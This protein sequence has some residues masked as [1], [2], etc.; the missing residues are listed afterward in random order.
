MEKINLTINELK[1]MIN[2]DTEKDYVEFTS[3]MLYHPKLKSVELSKFPFICGDL[4]YPKIAMFF[5][6]QKGYTEIVS[7]FFNKAK[8][9]EK[10]QEFMKFEKRRSFA[11]PQDSDST[12]E[13]LELKIQNIKTRLSDSQLSKTT[14]DGLN[15]EIEKI[16]R[17][18]Y[19]NKNKF[20]MKKSMKDDKIL[21]NNIMLMLKLL[22]ATSYPAKFNISSSFNEYILQKSPSMFEPEIDHNLEK[23]SYLKIDNKTLTITKITWLNDIMNHPLYR[24][25]MELLVDYKK[26][27]SKEVKR[28]DEELEE[29]WNFLKQKFL[30]GRY[31]ITYAQKSFEDYLEKLK[32]EGEI[33]NSNL[34]ELNY[35]KKEFKENIIQLIEQLSKFETL[36]KR[37]FFS[38]SNTFY[39]VIL[40]IKTLFDALRDSKTIITNIPV[41]FSSN[42]NR[43]IVDFKKIYIWSRIKTEYIKTGNIN[44]NLEGEDKDI[45]DEIMNK[46]KSLDKFLF[47]ST[48]IKDFITPERVC[49]NFNLQRMIMEYS[50]NKKPDEVNSDISTNREKINNIKNE[51]EKFKTSQEKTKEGNTNNIENINKL[52]IL[53]MNAKELILTKNK[54]TQTEKRDFSRLMQAIYNELI[55]MQ[56]MEYFKNK[57]N[58]NN[59]YIGACNINIYKVDVPKYEIYLAIDSIEGEYDEKTIKNVR[60]VR[61]SLYLG[62]EISDFFSG[63]SPYDI[64]NHRNIVS[65]RDLQTSNSSTQN[66]S[67]ELLKK[68]KGGKKNKTVRFSNRLFKNHRGGSSRKKNKKI[69]IS[70]RTY[71]NIHFLRNRNY[72][73]EL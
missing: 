6:A 29:E 31:K 30:D 45:A 70:T 47:F 35:N 40:N 3:S 26:Q 15:N 46:N 53:E 13:R 52:K 32:N 66:N 65:E 11:S 58:F 43:A 23:I 21:S 34:I 20:Y 12:K 4:E 54:T 5:I 64:I 28:I 51:I 39:M 27:M 42:L 37:F 56:K 25:L 14:S 22:F 61:D 7:L 24:K 18:L 67:L 9:R 19:D 49:S 72:T 41:D 38:D 2:T 16:Q 68:K 73:S 8:F 71:N 17:E 33:N 60:C 50:E 62:N 57:E 69:G 10:M 1:I 36:Q 44:I 55:Y 59:M 63:K 48:K